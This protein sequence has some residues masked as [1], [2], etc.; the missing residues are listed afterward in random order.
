MCTRSVADSFRLLLQFSSGVI[1]FASLSFPL[2]PCDPLDSSVPS[3]SIFCLCVSLSLVSVSVS[4]S[5]CLCLCVSPYASPSLM[6]VSLCLSVC[7]MTV[8][9]HPWGP[10][11][12]DMMLIFSY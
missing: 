6:S 3:G 1:S 4:E 7:N 8:F 2:F 11:V 9:D 10:C 12:V 5:V